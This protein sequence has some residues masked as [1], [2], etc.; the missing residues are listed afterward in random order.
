[1]TTVELLPLITDVEAPAPLPLHVKEFVAAVE[2][3]GY[4]GSPVFVLP[5]IPQD[6]VASRTP[7][8]TQPGLHLDQKAFD[9]LHNEGELPPRFEFELQRARGFNARRSAHQV[10][11]GDISYLDPSTQEMATQPVAVKRFEK[12]HQKAFHEYVQLKSLSE[13]GFAVF[14]PAGIL[15]T[16]S[17]EYLVT[18]YE[19]TVSTLDNENWA[20]MQSSEPERYF[21]EDRLEDMADALAEL[22]IKGRTFHG[23]AKTRNIVRTIDR[24]THFIDFESAE[25]VPDTNNWLASF[26][27]KAGADITSLYKSLEENRG[28]FTVSKGKSP[29]GQQRHEVFRDLFMNHYLLA[30][31]NYA[32]D[33]S[34]S[35]RQ[36]L[37]EAVCKL[38][39]DIYFAVFEDWDKRKI[40]PAKRDPESLDP[41]VILEV[42]SDND[43]AGEEETVQLRLAH[44]DTPNRLYKKKLKEK[45][46]NEIKGSNLPSRAA[47]IDTALWLG[48]VA[49]RSLGQK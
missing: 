15:I 31:A 22:H 29:N 19:D 1:M 16:D 36:Q 4:P 18:L 45:V 30:A 11:F 21:M 39:D 14:M 12:G 48:R 33:L 10:F 47:D 37:A 40:P 24:A 46:I 41:Y 17:A 49:E 27:N 3:S 35:E 2:Q 42:D 13:K 6:F 26:K 34:I 38:Q 25:T 20:Y 32:D 43:A 23:D 7:R 9:V 28:L 44:G 5:E 8:L